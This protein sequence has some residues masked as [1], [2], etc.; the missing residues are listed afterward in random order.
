MTIE[1]RAI[2]L[3][4]DAWAKWDTRESFVTHVA[5]AIE[6]AARAAVAEERER[7]AAVAEASQDADESWPSGRGYNGACKDIAA[8]IRKGAK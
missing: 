5:K 7:C 6:Q 1:E 8:A 3:A 4:A 2:N